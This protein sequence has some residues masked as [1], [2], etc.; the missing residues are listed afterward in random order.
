MYVIQRSR[1]TLPQDGQLLQGKMA[2]LAFG[3]DFS[4]C[5][6]PCPCKV[7]KKPVSSEFFNGD[8]LL[9]LVGLVTGFIV[10]YD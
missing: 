8:V 9:V 6:A 5:I 7:L 4:N 10:D 2:N 1:L 3:S